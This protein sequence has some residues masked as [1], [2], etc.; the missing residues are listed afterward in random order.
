M[1][2]YKAAG[3]FFRIGKSD[4]DYT[5]GGADMASEA[6][7]EPADTAKVATHSG[8]FGFEMSRI[9]SIWR[10]QRENVKA[11]HPI[12]GTWFDAY[13]WWCAINCLAAFREENHRIGSRVRIL[14]ENMLMDADA[15]L[16]NSSEA[17]TLFNAMH[18]ARHWW[19]H[20]S[21]G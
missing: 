18:A 1:L 14:R 5:E 13:I 8:E 4:T 12:G 17:E 20:S 6:I 10:T 3:R 9:G 21:I 7:A 15:F 2:N 11:E 16:N 19:N